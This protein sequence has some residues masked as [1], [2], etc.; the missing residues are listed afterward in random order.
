[1]KTNELIDAAL[2]W[3]VAKCEG[4]EINIDNLYD[5]P[6]KAGVVLRYGLDDGDVECLFQPS[7]DWAQAGPIIEREGVELR[8][9]YSDGGERDGWT[10]QVWAHETTVFE[11]GP[12]PLIAAMRCYVAS[13]L[14]DTVELPEEL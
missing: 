14:G 5:P 10:A 12:T 6:T 7:T 2:D 4:I 3:A 8:M 11:Y 9:S 1:M 13:K